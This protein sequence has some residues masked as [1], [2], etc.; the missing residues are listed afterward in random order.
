MSL[1]DEMERLFLHT[2][3][4]VVAAFPVSYC[5]YFV[6]PTDRNRLHPVQPS[7]PS[8]FDDGF[9][10]RFSSANRAFAQREQS[11]HISV[12]VFHHKANVFCASQYKNGVGILGIKHRCMFA[13]TTV[14]E[15]MKF[16]RHTV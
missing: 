4:S 3:F 5:W 14:M 13:K 12:H 16:E 11:S 15:T 8:T 6:H 1:L 10:R 2:E 9:L 7:A